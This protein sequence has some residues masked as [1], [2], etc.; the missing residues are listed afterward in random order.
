[1]PEENKNDPGLNQV[2]ISA[3]SSIYHQISLGKANPLVLAFT[4]N[5]TII[6]FFVVVGEKRSLAEGEFWGIIYFHVKDRDLDLSITG[7]AVRCLTLAKVLRERNETKLQEFSQLRNARVEE[8]LEKMKKWWV[9]KKVEQKKKGVKR[10]GPAAGKDDDSSS[11][12]G[13]GDAG[14]KG[15]GYGAGGGGDGGGDSGGDVGRGDGKKRKGDNQSSG[16]RL[17]GGSTAKGRTYVFSS[18]LK[19]LRT[20]SVSVVECGIDKLLNRDFQLT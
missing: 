7:D 16:S 11:N 19:A 1:V 14:G 17:Q 15:P 18:V 6:R 4:I 20:L 9:E 13:E 5:Q 12:F 2:M 8:G 3:A 10:S